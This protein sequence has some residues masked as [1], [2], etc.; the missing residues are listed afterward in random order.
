M[1]KENFYTYL[2]DILNEKTLTEKRDTLKTLK[3][4]LHDYSEQL[5]KNFITCSYC[6]KTFSTATFAFRENIEIRKKVFLETS[7][8]PNDFEAVFGDIEYVVKYIKCPGCHKIK[9]HSKK[10]VKVLKTYVGEL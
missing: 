8:D 3:N 9:E 4:L 6:K 7:P 1:L 5:E 2:N 10:A